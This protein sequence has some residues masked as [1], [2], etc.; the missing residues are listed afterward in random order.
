MADV[1]AVVPIQHI[2]PSAVKTAQEASVV[3]NIRVKPVQTV[4]P[5]GTKLTGKFDDDQLQRFVDDGCAVEIG[6]DRK[7]SEAPEVSQTALD[8]DATKLRDKLIADSL[9]DSTPE[10]D[11][12]KTAET[13]AKED[14]KPKVNPPKAPVS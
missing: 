13:V 3:S 11:R 7:F 8:N 2:S 10:E 4:I 9:R 1:V 14:E 6:K 12:P 5:I